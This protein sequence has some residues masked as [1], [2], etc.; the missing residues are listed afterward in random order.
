[1]DGSALC[2]RPSELAVN[3]MI[4]ARVIKRERWSDKC[5]WRIGKQ[6]NPVA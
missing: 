6:I 5:E 3:E 1:M 2:S 4:I